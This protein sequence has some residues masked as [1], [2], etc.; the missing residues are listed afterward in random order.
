MSRRLRF[1]V[2]CRGPRL[3]V[4]QVRCLD[5]LL[6]SGCAEL[7]L[8]IELG[9][10]PASC[11]TGSGPRGGLLWR[12]Y[13]RYAR[14]R[15][16]ALVPTNPPEQLTNVATISYTTRVDRNGPYERFEARDLEIIRSYRL[17]FILQLGGEALNGEILNAARYSV[18]GFRHHQDQEVRALA[19][20]FREIVQAHPTACATLRKLTGRAGG[21]IVLHRAIL[22][23]HWHLPTSHERMLLA[24]A[25]LCPRV[26]REILADDGESFV[27]PT[28][29]D[30]DPVWR[31]PTDAEVVAFLIRQISS[32][33]RAKMNKTFFVDDWAVGVVEQ[34]LEEILRT[35]RLS[36]VAWHGTGRSG[37]YVADPMPLADADDGSFLAEHF[38]YGGS[39]KGSIVR[40]GY[41]EGGRLSITPVLEREHHLSYPF[42]LDHGGQRYLIPESG[43]L[44]AVDLYA[45]DRDGRARSVRRLLEGLAANDP[46]LLRWDGRW[47]LFCSE[48]S[49]K[50]LAFHAD[51]L[52]GT[53]TPHRLNPLKIDVTSARPAG[54]LFERGGMLYRPAQD[55]AATYGAA[56]VLHRIVELTPDRYEEEPV[57]RIGPELRGPYAEGVHT[58]HV[59][60][61]RCLVDGKRSVFDLTWAVRGRS[62]GRKVRSRRARLAGAMH[63]LAEGGSFHPLEDGRRWPATGPTI[64]PP[65]SS[66]RP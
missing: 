63:R 5:R 44:G 4:W 42:V 48:D 34:T 38:E 17:D 43:E 65:G 14:R 23:T 10:A 22:A 62:Y 53:W 40:C 50:L 54:P 2:L 31:T 58:L 49:L 29:I 1:A 55:C 28:E 26:C 61:D 51:A 35:G 20:W 13:C 45:L 32:W 33:L 21:A 37:T 41:A 16:P 11:A 46:T 66:G 18:W 36:K 56:V 64:P 59:L 47:W 24:S 19:A 25:D 52:D 15:S 30:E 27:E 8:A 6:A 60:G 57:G 7:V 9:T 39:A 3:P 12:L